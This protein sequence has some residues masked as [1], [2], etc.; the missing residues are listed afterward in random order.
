M[1]VVY[2]S[3]HNRIAA[4]ADAD[5]CRASVALHVP[6]AISPFD[7]LDTTLGGFGLL[8]SWNTGNPSRVFDNAMERQPCD[9]SHK[10]VQ[11]G[12]RCPKGGQT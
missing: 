10:G 1:R 7:I 3:Y 12:Q 11:A 6:S 9:Q 5:Y 8:M 4:K 2:A